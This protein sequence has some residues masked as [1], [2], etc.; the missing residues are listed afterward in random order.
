MA[1]N[2]AG[3]LHQRY[4]KGAAGRY[5]LEGFAAELPRVF[6]GGAVAA[7]GGRGMEP[8]G[9]AP[10]AA[11]RADRLISPVAIIYPLNGDR[12]VLGGRAETLEVVLKAVSRAPLKTVT[13][14]LDGEEAA[15]TGPPYETTLKLGR[16]HHRL[17]VSTPDGLGDSVEVQV[18]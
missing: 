4:D 13:W 15:A 1:A 18:Q 16:G 8:S 6:E 12:Y 5:R 17:T 9:G 7:A 2:Y 3:W 14:F 10:G 11:W